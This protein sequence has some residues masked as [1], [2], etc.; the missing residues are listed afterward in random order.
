MNSHAT[1][2][3]LYKIATSTSKTSKGTG[4]LMESFPAYK[5]HPSSN[6]NYLKYFLAVMQINPANC[7]WPKAVIFTHWKVLSQKNWGSTEYSCPD[8]P[9]AG[10]TAAIRLA[11]T[12]KHPFWEMLIPNI[13]LSNAWVPLIT[14]RTSYTSIMYCS[15]FKISLP[16]SKHKSS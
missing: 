8:T 3:T 15:K 12:H 7:T 5:H 6:R 13:I 10:L 1:T 4:K 16:S 14:S 11:L 2:A 9:E